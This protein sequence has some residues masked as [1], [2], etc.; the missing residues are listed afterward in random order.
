MYEKALFENVEHITSMN[1][2]RSRSH[3]LYVD[4][5][6]KKCLT[7]FDDKRYILPNGYTYAFGHYKIK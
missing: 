6:H 7:A 2:I 3:Q 4:T 5:V 1:L